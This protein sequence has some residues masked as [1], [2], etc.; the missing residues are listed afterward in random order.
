MRVPL[1][2][3]LVLTLLMAS[4][5][6]GDEPQPSVAEIVDQGARNTAALKGF[7]FVLTVENG[8]PR[9]EGLTI[10][11][12]EGDIVVPDGLRAKVSGT[13]SG[14][15]LESELIAVGDQDFLRDPVTQKWRR[16]EVGANPAAFFDPAEGVLAIM[17]GAARLEKAGSE[18]VGGADSYRL[19][20]EV[21]ATDLV[22]LLG[23]RLARRDVAVGLW[24]GKQDLMLRRIRL[25][26][27]ALEGEPSNIVR[28]IEI[29]DFDRI[30]EIEPPE[31]AP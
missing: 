26:G 4:C 11:F 8:A 31:V 17:E 2:A 7:H 24:V 14:V 19:R 20:G 15:P 23:D 3:A 6:D 10:T 5:G 27:P 29:S 1:A 9:T 25:E 13:L 28:T 12:A 22:T 30:V 16:L 21:S 18:E